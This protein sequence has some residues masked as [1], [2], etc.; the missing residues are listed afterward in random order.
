MKKNPKY[1]QLFFCLSI[2]PFKSLRCNG[3]GLKFFYQ[4]EEIKN[5]RL[6]ML[7]GK[8]ELF[9]E[10]R[11]DTITIKKIFKISFLK[12]KKNIVNK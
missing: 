2:M 11:N 7:N 5:L 4:S 6:I 9:E 1:C 12:N 8:T 3:E 10:R